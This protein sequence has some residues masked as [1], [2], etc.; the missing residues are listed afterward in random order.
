MLH[1]YAALYN[2]EPFLSVSSLLC[3]ADAKL[4][5][6]RIVFQTQLFPSLAFWIKVYIGGKSW[7]SDDPVEMFAKGTQHMFRSNLLSPF[8]FRAQLCF[9]NPA[10]SLKS[11]EV[12]MGFFY[13]YNA[14]ACC[15]GYKHV[16]WAGSLHSKSHTEAGYHLSGSNNDKMWVV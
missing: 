7:Q 15:S 3:L 11:W 6:F 8:L 13:Y 10:F 2:L 4:A 9:V 1:V 5:L 12:G 16:L 14:A